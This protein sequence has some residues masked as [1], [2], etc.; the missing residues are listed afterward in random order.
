MSGEDDRAR[1]DAAIGERI[2]RRRVELG[3]TQEQL[4]CRLGLSY[5]QIQKYER[6]TNSISASR[7]Y[8][9]ARRLD[10]AP[11]YFFADLDIPKDEGDD[12][13]DG[14]LACEVARDYAR[15]AD[16]DV[17]SAVAGLL[18]AVAERQR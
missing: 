15:V 8:A 1:V 4:A 11:G 13:G 14:R 6:G 3:L 2:R 10:V 18:R 17:R 9:L 5:Q 7:L 16:A 12:G